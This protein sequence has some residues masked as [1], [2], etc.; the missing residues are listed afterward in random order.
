M[1]PVRTLEASTRRQRPG[2]AVIELHDEINAIAEE[3]LNATYTEAER[4]EPG[5]ILVNVA[6]VEY[7]NTTGTALIVSLLA[8]VCTMRW[9]LLACDLSQHYVVIFTITRLAVFMSVFPDDAAALM[10]ASAAAAE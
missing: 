2:V 10:A 5:A 1:T 8:L 7:I 9:R 4:E 6:D 3:A